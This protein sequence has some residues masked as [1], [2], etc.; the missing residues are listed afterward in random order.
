MK[1]ALIIVASLL[2]GATVLLG[3]GASPATAKDPPRSWTNE[4]ILNCDGGQ[5]RTYLTPAGFGTPFHV[6]DSQDVIIPVH[7]EVTF[8]DETSSVTTVHV[9]GFEQNNLATVHCTYTD[10][11]GLFVELI[12]LRA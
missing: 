1:R 2:V 4:R 3:P 10:P 8:P 5:V 7:V 12:G 11:A 9:P 6:V